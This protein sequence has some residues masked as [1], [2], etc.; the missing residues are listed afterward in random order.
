MYFFH[1]IFVSSMN[2]LNNKISRGPNNSFTG[3][4]D[5]KQYFVTS[6]SAVM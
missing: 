3:S 6:A 4:E 2:V 5:Y 1:F